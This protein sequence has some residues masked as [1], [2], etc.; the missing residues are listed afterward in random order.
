MD[1][2]LRIDT[3]VHSSGIS[4]CSQLDYKQIISEKKKMG[5]DGIIL[6]NHCQKWYYPPEEH[7][8]FIE[9]LIAEY[10]AA[11]EYA[12]TQDF[13]VW[14]GIE[15]TLHEPHYAD[16]LLFGV[17]EAF[18][19]SSSCLY[20]LK[21]KELFEYCN[22][23]G[24]LMVQ[25]HAFREGHSPCNPEYMHG[26]EINCNERDIDNIAKVEAFAAEHKLMVTCGVDYHQVSH[27]Y[28]G[29]MFVGEDCR[30]SVDFVRE[31]KHNGKTRVFLQKEEKEYPIY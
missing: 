14:L 12:Q 28:L 18:L 2:V 16:W 4:L 23:C 9:R 10:R 13:Q 26:I 25:A 19:R 24:I 15:V 29:G 7:A 30:S 6:M 11:A 3:H 31:I 1:K 20:Q 27:D 5:Y 17:T 21:Q 22:R 8:S